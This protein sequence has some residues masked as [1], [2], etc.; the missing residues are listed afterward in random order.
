MIDTHDN[1]QVHLFVTNLMISCLLPGYKFSKLSISISVLNDN[2]LTITTF[3]CNKSHTHTH[4]H[5]ENEIHTDRD[6]YRK[7]IT[8][9]VS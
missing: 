8:Q 5:R 4:T 2:K 6:I 9:Q 1:K 3:N 7:D